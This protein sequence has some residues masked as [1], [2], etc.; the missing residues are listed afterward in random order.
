MENTPEQIGESLG[1]ESVMNGRFMARDGT[2][3]RQNP[4]VIHLNK[5]L[6]FAATDLPF[7]ANL[8]L[9]WSEHP[10][11]FFVKFSTQARDGMYLGR[12]FFIQ[13]EDDRV[14]KT[15]ANYK[16]HPKLFCSIHDDDATMPWRGLVKDWG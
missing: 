2:A 13:G 12:L 14:G 5:K 3:R 1:F 16:N 7:L 6:C 11:A 10:Q 9:E 4:D 15:W 8:L